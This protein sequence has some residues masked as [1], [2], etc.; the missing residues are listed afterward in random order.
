MGALSSYP[1]SPQAAEAHPQA[2]RPRRTEVHGKDW[3]GK[4]ST[5][6]ACAAGLYADEKVAYFPTSLTLVAPKR[7][8]HGPCCGIHQGN[9]NN[10]MVSGLPEPLAT[11]RKRHSMGRAWVSCSHGSKGFDDHDLQHLLVDISKLLDVD[12]SPCRSCA[13]P[14]LRAAPWSRWTRSGY[15][16]QLRPCAAKNRSVAY[17]PP[18][19]CGTGSGSCRIQ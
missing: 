9:A 1:Q 16:K 3:F 7:F 13:C 15:T 18:A 8:S 6:I 12:A 4:E 10:C 11:T 2:R 19:R 5:V 14:A 17:R